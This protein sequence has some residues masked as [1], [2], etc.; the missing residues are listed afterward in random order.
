MKRQM[1]GLL[2]G[3][4]V[5]M[6][7]FTFLSRAADSM[8]IPRV[9]ANAPERKKITHSVSGGG[10]VV[11]NREEAV[12]IPEGQLVKSISVEVGSAVK[13]GDLLFEVDLED[14][15]EQIRRIK[16]E[17]EMLSLQQRDAQ[18]QRE[19]QERKQQIARARA[20]EDYQVATQQA[21]EAASRALQELTRA[22]EELEKARETQKEAKKEQH[23]KEQKQKKGKKKSENVQSSDTEPISLE[24]LE[25]AVRECE[26]A[27]EEAL[28][29]GE[30]AVRTAKRGLEDAGEALAND[31]TA[32]IAGIEKKQKRQ[33]LPKLEKL[34]EQKGRI[35]APVSGV[36]TQT[37]I[38]VGERTAD[39]AAMLLADASAGCKLVAQM[40][41]DQEEYLARNAPVTVTPSGSEQEIR[42]LK[43]DSIKVNEQDETLLDVSIPLPEGTLEIGSSATAEVVRESEPYSVCVPIEA[44]YQGD[45]NQYYV[46]LVEQEDTV[47]GEVMTAKRMDVTVLDKNSTY[48]ALSEDSLGGEVQVIVSSDR[49]LEDGSRIRLEG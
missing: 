10:K 39:G 25:E 14:V 30:E 29:S 8:T 6:L 20:E 36:I 12:R 11:Q 46:L 15:K 45:Q 18:S 7:L 35:T 44:L 40:P 32:R 33:E 1:M 4:L 34:V 31:S 43:V 49:V 22:K 37:N 27:Y 19:E 5:L 38:S 9:T 13:E 28:S 47:L 3:F 17:L 24:Q 16:Q 41:A 48:A 23:G 26:A 42:D 2:A 21:D